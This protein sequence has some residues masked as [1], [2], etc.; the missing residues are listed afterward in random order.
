MPAEPKPVKM[1]PEPWLEPGPPPRPTGTLCCRCRLPILGAS[2]GPRPEPGLLPRAAGTGGCRLPELKM[3]AEA[4]EKHNNKG[5]GDSD[6]DPSLSTKL[7]G[8]LARPFGQSTG[9]GFSFTRFKIENGWRSVLM[10][11]QDAFAPW[12]GPD[13]TVSLRTLYEIGRL[14]TYADP[15]CRHLRW[16]EEYSFFVPNLA[17]LGLDQRFSKDEILQITAFSL[18][19]TA[20]HNEVTPLTLDEIAKINPRLRCALFHE[21]GCLNRDG[22][23]FGSLR[24]CPR[25][26]TDY[27]V[28]IVPDP[29]TDRPGGRLLVFSTW[30]G[31]GDGNSGLRCSY[32][33]THQTSGPTGRH[34]GLGYMRHFFMMSED[35]RAHADDPTY[36]IDIAEIQARVASVRGSQ[37]EAPPEYTAVAEPGYSFAESDG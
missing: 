21:A 13:H 7:A 18:P 12:I 20:L 25:C 22:I 6:L 17:N 32:W 19:I 4:W 11:Q 28:S 16:D 15:I 10:R 33:R 27:A 29:T 8:D 26:Y 14:V 36:Q 9:R 23:A 34:Y 24:S 3:V 5:G 30:K 31:L 2:H 1:S 35:P 37:N